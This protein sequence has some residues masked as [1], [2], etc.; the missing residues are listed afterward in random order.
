M[1]KYRERSVKVYIDEREP[2]W[3]ECTHSWNNRTCREL[4]YFLAAR[5]GLSKWTRAR[6]IGRDASKPNVRIYL[7]D[8]S[9]LIHDRRW[10]KSMRIE[11]RMRKLES[12]LQ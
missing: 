11:H 12:E 7:V 3:I 9:V 5:A 1:V 10:S 4:R 8:G 6:A 2:I